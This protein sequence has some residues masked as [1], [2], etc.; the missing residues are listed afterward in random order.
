[1]KKKIFSIALI[2]LLVI[3]CLGGVGNIQIASAATIGQQLLQPE[4]GWRRYDDTDTNLT[5]EGGV[6][7]S[8]NLHYGG[9]EREGVKSC[10]FKFYGTK[11]L[12]LGY[13]YGSYS[14][15][16]EVT[17]DNKIVE[18]FSERGADCGQVI[19]YIKTG[20]D[21]GVHIVTITNKMATTNGMV[22]DAIDI[23]KDGQLIPSNSSIVLDNSSI[24]LLAGDSQKLKATTTP[25][26][27]PVEWSVD[28]GAIAT[29]D[30]EGNVTA[31]SE[32]TATVTAKIKGTDIK[33]TC[34]VNVKKQATDSGNAI[35]SISLD[36]GNTKEYDVTMDKV[37]DFIKWY[38]ARDKDKSTNSPTY[39]FDKNIN[40]YKSVKESIVHAKIDSYEV[41]QY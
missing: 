8:S 39:T 10:T 27:L 29:V 2:I 11:F 18:T 25:E 30:Q 36:N 9:N 3:T 7:I 24:E 34:V 33:T 1:M 35:L 32:G 15:N 19:H 38:N 28:N 37:N 5:Y 23:D 4:D 22:L 20:L 14:T 31:V 6:H 13:R 16:I 40:P 21:R 26:G 12:I 41:R 17:I